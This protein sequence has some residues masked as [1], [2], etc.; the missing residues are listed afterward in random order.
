MPDIICETC[1][2]KAEADLQHRGFQRIQLSG[3]PLESNADYDAACT[4]CQV[5][6]KGPLVTRT[7]DSGQSGRALLM[8]VGKIVQ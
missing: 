1:A 8:I 3:M 2:D 4:R 5:R 7:F 6:I